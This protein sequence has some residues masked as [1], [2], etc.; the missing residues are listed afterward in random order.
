MKRLIL[1][2]LVS[3]VAGCSDDANFHVISDQEVSNYVKRHK[4]D[5]EVLIGNIK[6]LPNWRGLGLLLVN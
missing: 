5:L 4:A 3:L 6:E 2:F 1:L